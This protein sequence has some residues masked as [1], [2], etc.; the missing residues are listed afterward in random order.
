MGSLTSLIPQPGPQGPIGTNV[1]VSIVAGEDLAARDCVFIASV[2]ITGRTSGRGYKANA[3]VGA[4]S[5][6]AFVAGLA[7]SAISSGAT[8]SVRISGVMTGFSGLT[9]G[10]PQYVSTTAGLLTDA[11]P[12]NSVLVGLALSSTDLLVNVRG[13]QVAVLTAGIK[14]YFAGGNTGANV[15]T[16]DKMSFSTE[17][18]AAQSTANLSQSRYIPYGVG[19][20]FSKGYIGG[21]Y[22]DNYA[23]ITDKITFST[24]ITVAQTSANLSANSAGTGGASEGTTKGYWSGGGTSGGYSAKTDKITFSSDTTAAQTSANLTLARSNLA[25]VGGGSSKG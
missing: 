20:T 7:T 1:D 22:S 2:G 8:G 3:S 18:T 23:K 13:S 6:L 5:S 19:N 15:T 25:G 9:P 21:G 14:G 11:T 16:T 17:T 10:L 24:D 4:Y 12:S